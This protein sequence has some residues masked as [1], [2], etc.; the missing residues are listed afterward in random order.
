M[1]SVVQPAYHAFPNGG[2]GSFCPSP[3]RRFNCDLVFATTRI[4]YQSSY[5]QTTAAPA[6][7]QVTL[8]PRLYPNIP[9]TGNKIIYVHSAGYVMAT[10]KN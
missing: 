5:S 2:Q 6:N 4:K 9:L 10:Q 3:N 1:I 7:L 8:P